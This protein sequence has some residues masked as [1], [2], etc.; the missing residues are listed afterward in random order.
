ME[1]M[2]SRLA[3]LRLTASVVV[4]LSACAAPTPLPPGP[5]REEV[6]ELRADENWDWWQTMS[7]GQP[8]PQVEV[9]QFVSYELWPIYMQECVTDAG[10]TGI[11]A[12]GDSIVFDLQPGQELEVNR[13]YYV[14]FQKFPLEINDSTSEGLYSKAQ[15]SW[16]YDFFTQRVSPCLQML[17][18]AVDPAPDR[19]TFID[20]FYSYELWTP[21]ASVQPGYLTWDSIDR[22][23]PRPPQIF[24][25]LHP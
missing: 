24:E 9:E 13:A 12:E 16:L 18:Y 4:V 5:T 11:T 20:S 19:E 7:G 8:Q 14:C 3:V 1:V 15:V 21:Y 23:C 10:Y 25:F 2:T 17:G 22:E 6:L